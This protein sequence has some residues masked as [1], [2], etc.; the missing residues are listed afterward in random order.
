MGERD[1]ADLVRGAAGG[2]E[3]AWHALVDRYA[4]T[5]WSVV[6]SH[7]LHPGDAADVPGVDVR[8]V[9]LLMSGPDETAALAR[10]ALDAAGV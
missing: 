1:A 6:R 8:S 7:R 10:A 5:V 2:D 4:R 3:S 9:P